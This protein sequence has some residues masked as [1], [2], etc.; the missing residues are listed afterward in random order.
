VLILYI[1]PRFG[2]LCQGKSGNPVAS[3]RF[4]ARKL[5]SRYIIGNKKGAKNLIERDNANKSNTK[6]FWRQTQIR[7]RFFGFLNFKRGCVNRLFMGKF[8]LGLFLKFL[9]TGFR[10]ESSLSNAVF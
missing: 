5:V 2:T 1:F 10:F 9:G 7:I 3:Y 8:R 6:Q 4:Q